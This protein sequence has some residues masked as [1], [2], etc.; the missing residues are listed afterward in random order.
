MNDDIA[1][2]KFLHRNRLSLLLKNAAYTHL[3][4]IREKN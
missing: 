3:A 4:E 1:K 2:E